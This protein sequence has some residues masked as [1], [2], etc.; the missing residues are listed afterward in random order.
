LKC[1]EKF[2]FELTDLRKIEI[3]SSVEFLGNCCFLGCAQLRAVHFGCDS[4]LKEMC[5]YAFLLT[6]VKKIEIPRECE[7]LIGSCL[8]GMNDVNICSGNRF[9]VKA[10]SFIQSADK[11]TL[12]RYIGEDEIVIVNRNV[13]RI[14]DECFTLS[15]SIHED[16]FEEG[17]SLIRI[18]EYAFSEMKL[19]KIEIP[20]SVEFIGENCFG[21][22]QSLC[23][24]IFQSVSKLKRIED[25]A[26]SGTGLRTVT[27]PSSVEYL[28][29]NCFLGCCS[30]DEVTI[31]GR[32]K[33]IGHG[34][35]PPEMK[36]LKIPHGT[37]L[38]FV[39]PRK[40]RIEYI[41]VN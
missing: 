3:P 4:S 36:W 33:K 28:G 21:K 16:I 10:E 19:K 1:I 18:E 27:I 31:E 14:S 9:F 41:D 24:V 6:R 23:E 37:K 12:L 17:S 2:A 25:G 38:N 15:Q 13:E 8:I 40:C 35:L 39:L 26:F 7:I 20:S 22:C 34:A 30:L 11:K 5:D 29:M 32:I